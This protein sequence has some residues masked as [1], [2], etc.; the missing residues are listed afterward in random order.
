MVVTFT[1][2]ASGA[3][4][5]FGTCPG[6][7]NG[8]VHDLP[9]GHQR[10]RQRLGMSTFTTN[11]T[12]GCVLGGPRSALPGRT[13]P[14]RRPS[15]R[16]AHAEDGAPPSPAYSGG[17]QSTTVSTAFTNPLLAQVTR[18]LRQPGLGCHGDVHRPGRHRRQQ[19][20]LG[21]DQRRHLPG[22]RRRTAVA[23]CTTTTSAT[24]LASSLTLKA[25]THAGTYNVAATS[26][27]HHPEPGHLLRDEH[28]CD[29]QR[30]HDDHDRQ[31][32]E[33]NGRRRL[34][35]DAGRQYRRQLR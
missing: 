4:G 21:L 12:A 13:P 29:D 17:A 32:P 16:P 25:D 9:G 33:R 23:S 6:G 14:R 28:G 8:L 31:R 1:A 19:H 24:G 7:N 22:H 18:H 30:Q 20:R 5:T 3:S 2:P 11:H 10:I 26:A 35:D 27:R 15:L 34:L